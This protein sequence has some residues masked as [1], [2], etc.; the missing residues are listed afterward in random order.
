MAILAVSPIVKNSLKAWSFDFTEGI[1]S[2]IESRKNYLKY[3]KESYAFYDL[4]L[5]SIDGNI[6]WTVEEESDLGTNLITGPY[7]DTSLAKVYRLAKN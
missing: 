3:V 4:F 6:W 7:K 5:I 1:D 2:D